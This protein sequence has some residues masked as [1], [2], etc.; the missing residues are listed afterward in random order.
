ME[1]VIGVA[2]DSETVDLSSI[3]RWRGVVRRPWADE[4]LAEIQQPTTTLTSRRRGLYRT[5]PCSTEDGELLCKRRSRLETLMPSRSTDHM[6]DTQTSQDADTQASN[7]HNAHPWI[8][9]TKRANKRRQLQPHYVPTQQLRSTPSEPALR[10]SRPKPRLPGIPPLP[11]EDYKLA[12]RPHGG[13]NL[14]KVSP[15]TL[16]L[17]VAHAANIRSEKPD[18]KLR[19]DKNQ[20]VLTISTSSEHIATALGQITKITAHAATYDITFYGIAPDNSCKGVV[21]GMGNEITP[22]DFLAKAEVPFYEVLT[23]RRLG[24][25]G[26]MVLTFC[27]KRV[28]VFVNAY[29]QALR[30]YLYKRT[31]PHC[32]KCNKTGHREDVCPQP[33][34]TPECRVC[35]DSLSPNN[36]E[37]RPSCKLCIGGHPTAAKP[38]P[39][40]FLPPVNRRK[41]PRSATSTRKA[42]SLSPSPGWQ[43]SASGRA[44]RRRSRS[45]DKSVPKRGNSSSQ[46]GFAGQQGSQGWHMDA[47][48]HHHGQQSGSH[49]KAQTG[50]PPIP[51]PT[52]SSWESALLSLRRHEQM[53]LVQWARRVAEGNGVQD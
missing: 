26:A 39:K 43:S 12:I 30:C 52:P 22:D 27:G 45:R 20:N 41:R 9:I 18:I 47:T 11:A 36:H 3:L 23:C 28:P 31:I 25:S 37:C 17:A 38:C 4:R 40:R 51:D 48:M 35:G 24:D 10:Q 8:T 46:S 1:S 2:E 19:V 49:K 53:Q 15:K 34:D 44:A 13:I 33:F 14:S 21:N 42:Q 6:M 29:G 50:V 16:L 5:P 32:R 7:E